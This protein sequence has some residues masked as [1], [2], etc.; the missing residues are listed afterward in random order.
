M[1]K[2]SHGCTLDCFDACKFNVY[3]EEGNVLKIEGD[4]NHA[5]TKGFICKKGKAHLERLNHKDRIYTPLLKINGEWH[6][7]SFKKA[8]EIIS[9]KLN[10]YK[11]KYS[12][13]SIMY[14]FFYE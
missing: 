14:L 3:V 10:Y 7:I 8:I 2:L 11:E 5:Y 9:K 6:E 13:K 1:K 4:K 12:T